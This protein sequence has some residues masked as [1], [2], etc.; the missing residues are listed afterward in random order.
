MTLS[1]HEKKTFLAT[2]DWAKSWQDLPWAH[3]DPTL[4]LAELCARRQPGRALDIGCG[5]G[6]DSVYLARQGWQVTALDFMPK[7]LEYTQARARE[8]GVSVTP[9]EADITEWSAAEP[10]DLVLDHG[11]LHNMDPVRHAAYRERVLNALADDGDLVLLHWHPRFA[12]QPNGKMGPRRASREELL[13]FFA[14]DLQERFF[15]LEEFEDLPDM[16]GGSMSQAYYWFRR[17]QSHRK[18]RDLLAQVRATLA[19]HKVDADALPTST[20]DGQVPANAASLELLAK[21]VGPGR[22]GLR[23]LVPAAGE[24]PET[25][26][27]FAAHAGED[28]RRVEDLLR[29]FVSTEHGGIC[30]AAPKCAQ[31]EVVYCK[32]LRDR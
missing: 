25:I 14:P 5:A 10:F 6:T 16:V 21:L 13:A 17:N 11:L 18:P 20:G 7:A 31:C 27:A 12:G 29:V 22:L 24:V 28:P 32:R 3:D 19:R 23:H 4:F 9:V 2:Y 30:G 15:A 1:T 26:R 8:A